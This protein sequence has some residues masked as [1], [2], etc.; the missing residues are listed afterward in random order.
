MKKNK[1]TSTI[2][3]ICWPGLGQFYNGEVAKGILVGL[4]SW[5]IIP[6]ILGIWDARVTSEKMNKGEKTI[7]PIN[8][9][10]MGIYLVTVL[11]LMMIAV[12][13]KIPKD[14]MD[15]VAMLRGVEPILIWV[16]STNIFISVQ[17]FLIEKKHSLYALITAFLI[18]TVLASVGKLI[19]SLVMSFT[20][21]AISGSGTYIV[22]FAGISEGLAVFFISIHLII[23][24][25]IA[26]G[27]IIAIRKILSI[28]EE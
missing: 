2:L 15:L 16:I 7:R 9:L 17:A 28:Q 24:S 4:S 5:L 6:W 20:D 1:T 18:A 12:W 3:A 19:F 21:L 23:P 25:V 22:L 10:A 11:V 27:S 8:Y 14:K 26:F 13:G